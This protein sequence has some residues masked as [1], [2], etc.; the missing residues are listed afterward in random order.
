MKYAL[1][2]Y[3]DPQARGQD[4]AAGPETYDNWVDF[5]QA[6]KESIEK[7]EDMMM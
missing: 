2:L 5:T 6:L 7:E 1:L 4:G 3:A